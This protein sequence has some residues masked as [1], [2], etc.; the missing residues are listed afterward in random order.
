MSD[1]P[2][3]TDERLAALIASC[4]HFLDYE[5]RLLEVGMGCELDRARWDGVIQGLTEL[6]ERRANEPNRLAKETR[7]WLEQFK[8]S[9]W[10]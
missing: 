4:Q 1:R 7:Q 2:T 8:S 10:G 3:L 5:T 9:D 6:Q